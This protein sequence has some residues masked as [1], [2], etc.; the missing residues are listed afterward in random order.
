MCLSGESSVIDTWVCPVKWS[1][2]NI[3]DSVEFEIFFLLKHHSDT[4]STLSRIYIHVNL[5]I[6]RQV[7]L[8][9]LEYH[10]INK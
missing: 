1:T 9:E 3:Y 5:L 2:S 4:V 10:Q 7:R 6:I 8:P